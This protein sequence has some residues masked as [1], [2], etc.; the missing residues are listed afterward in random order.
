MKK[1]FFLTLVLLVITALSLQA[2]PGQLVWS[3]GCSINTRNFTTPSE[4]LSLSSLDQIPYSSKWASGYDREVG[5]TADATG[6]S[7]Y[8]VFSGAVE[9]EGFF[10]WNYLAIDPSVLPRDLTYTLTQT[11]TDE[12]G[13]VLRT[14]VCY[15]TLIPGQE[16]WSSGSAINTRDLSSPS[17]PLVI[18]SLEQIPYSSKWAYGYDRVADVTADATSVSDYPVFSGDVES[19][20]FF[21]WDYLIVDPAVLPRDQI[22][23]LSHTITDEEGTVLRTLA[24]YV[25]IM[26]S[27]EVWSP[28]TNI[29]TLKIAP[30]KTLTLL[31]TDD[32]TYGTQW[33]F[34]Y[35]RKITLTATIDSYGTSGFSILDTNNPYEFFTSDEEASGT[36][37]WKNYLK[38]DPS[39]L[40]RDAIYTLSYSIYDDETTF[41]TRDAIV[42]IAIL[43]E[44]GLIIGF[45]LLALGLIRRK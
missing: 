16:V 40:P 22:Y 39:V 1:L 20:G 10:S 43:P 9:S 5:V 7:D 36:Y 23:T 15:V 19:E 37:A 18:S 33:A 24:C 45:V 31:P 11:I 17:A 6:V 2:A 13:N 38:V 44:P 41:A 42:K 14:L 12:E 4:P 35:D 25:S 8:P 28:G 3:S 21:S 34:G 27:Q 32:I 30:G 29:D 26:N